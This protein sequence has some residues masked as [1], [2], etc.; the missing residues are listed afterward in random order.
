MLRLVA[1]LSVV[2]S[3]VVFVQSAVAAGSAGSAECRFCLDLV[4]LQTR[5]GQPWSAGKPVTLVVH[6]VP[7]LTGTV[8]NTAT[9]TTTT[10][11]TTRPTTRGRPTRR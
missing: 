9:G 4:T 8:D 3:S 11:E 6:V 7:S 1:M 5:D 10:V 2:L